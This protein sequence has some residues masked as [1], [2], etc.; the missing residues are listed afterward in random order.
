MIR[1]WGAASKAPGRTIKG[2]SGYIYSVSVSNDGKLLASAG[3]GRTIKVWDARTGAELHTLAGH[4]SLVHSVAFSSDG[5]RIL[6]ASR[7][8]TARL[9]DAA[10]GRQIGAPLVG[11][12]LDGQVGLRAAHRHGHERDVVH[13]FAVAERFDVV[14]QAEEVGEVLPREG[15]LLEDSFPVRGEHGKCLPVGRGG[16]EAV[17]GGRS[18]HVL[19]E[20]E[21]LQAGVQPGDALVHGEGRLDR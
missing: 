12:R 1:I 21:R 13:G 14:A 18:Q 6:T 5:A 3:A 15:E 16:E 19:G 20:A 7:D 11:Q 2:H 4:T 10:T 17:G 8:H 9:W